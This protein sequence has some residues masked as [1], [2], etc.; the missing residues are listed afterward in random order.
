MGASVS[1]SRNKITDEFMEVNF[2]LK[3]G[4]SVKDYLFQVLPK[5]ELLEREGSKKPGMPINI[6]IIG[7]DSL[8]YSN[9][10]RKL[11]K[12]YQFLKD[13]LKALFYK[14]HN[15]VGDGTTPQLT[16][17][18]TGKSVKEQY[19]ARRGIAGAKPIDGWTWI[20]KELKGIIRFN[21]TPM[22]QRNSK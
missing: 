15:I 11:P 18:L 17:M 2:K 4:R 7:I 9:M 3:D 5:N 16:A 1:V 13:D 6:L 20:Y 10:R 8:S 22:V 14:G 19:Q 21:T 12:L